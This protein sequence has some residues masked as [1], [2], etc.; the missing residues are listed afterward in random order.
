ML[1]LT[2]IPTLGLL[3]LQN[4][5]VQTTVSEYITKNLSGQLGVDI[6]VSSVHYSFFK[7]LQLNNVYIADRSGDTLMYAE[8]C[9][10]QVKHFR[11]DKKLIRIRKLSFENALL[12]INMDESN[13]S[14]LQFFVD[15][16]RRDLPPEEKNVLEINRME[17][18]DSRYRRVDPHAQTPPSGVDLKN[19]EIRDLDIDIRDFRFEA[20]TTSMRIAAA[21]GREPRGFIMQ[22]VAFDLEFSKKYMS[23]TRGTIV[24]PHSTA[25]IA[26][27]AFSY[28]NPRNFK[29]A[30]D[31]VYMNLDTRGSE[32]D[33]KDIVL[34]F[35]QVDRLSGKILLDGKLTGLLGDLK[36]SDIYL[37]YLDQTQLEFDMALAGLP[38]T[39]SLFMD[40]NFREFRTVPNE[41]MEL[42]KHY[43]L[44]FLKG[45][46]PY[47]G[48]EFVAYQGSFRGYKTDFETAGS[49]FSNLGKVH[50]D[51]NMRP[52]TARMLTV[53]GRLSSDGFDL[54]NLVGNSENLG[55]VEFN[56]ELDGVKDGD[57]LMALVSGT[58][59]TLGIYGY[60][61]SNIRL[62]G[63]F[64][65]KKFDGSVVIR[66]PHI[67]VVFSG[68]VDFENKIPAFD[69]TMDVARLRPY[70]LNLRD[71][72]PA[73]FTSFL[74]ETDMTGS[75]LNNLNGTIELV[76]S[77]FRRTGKE[78]RLRDM[79]LT[80]R[81][82]PDTSW[83]RLRS[84]PLDAEIS[85]N[86]SMA[87]L[88]ELFTSLV[89]EHFNI[90]RNHPPKADRT[91]SFS[92][93][94]HFK[95]TEQWLDFFFPRF[96]AVPGII[97]EG[98]L[99]QLEKD[100]QFNLRGRLPEV[101]FR[102]VTAR[103]LQFSIH[104]D[105]A[106][107]SLD[108]MSDQ[109]LSSSNLEIENTV[110]SM[111]FANDS[112][113]FSFQ[114][115]NDSLPLYAGNI[116]STGI[117]EQTPGGDLV[118]T[119]KINPSE[120]HYDN[121]AFNIPGS[122]LKIGTNGMVMDSIYVIGTDQYL[123][124]HGNYTGIPGDS[125]TISMQNLNLQMINHIIENMP[126]D[127]E[128]FLSGQTTLKTEANS[129]VVTSNLTASELM[130]NNHHLGRVRILADWIRES[131]ELQLGI[132]SVAPAFSNIIDIS[133]TYQPAGNVID[134][135]TKLSAVK[136]SM[137]DQYFEN[138]LE[139]LEGEADIDLVLTGTLTDPEIN[140]SI[141]FDH[142]SL[143]LK[144]TKARYSIS[145]QI[146][147]NSNDIYFDNF[148]IKDEF[149][150]TVIANG[151][152][153][154]GNFSELRIDLDL[155]ADNFN[156]LQTTRFDNEQFYGDIFASGLIN[157]EGPADQ[158][159]VKATANTER[160]TNLKLPLYN[161]SEIQTTDFI[162]FIGTDHTDETP[163]PPLKTTG[164][165]NFTLDMELDVSSNTTVQLI[166]D[167]KVGD[168]IEA[169]GE[170]T[171]KFEIDE[172]GEFS[173]FGNVLIQ[174][175]EYLFT[176]QNVINKRFRVKPGGSISWNGPPRSAILD[177]D[178]IYET[179]ASTFNLSPEPSE[180]M[181]KRIPVHCLL[182]LEG[183]LTNPTIKPSI[184]LPTA[185]PE[186]RSL[187]QTSIGTDE[188][189]MRQFISLLV[190]NNFISSSEFGVS[191][192]AGT[193]TGVAGVTA[194]ELL[195]NQLSNWLSQISNDFDIGVNYR[196]GDAISS[197][198]VEVALSTQL[199]NDRIV[200]SGNLDVLADEVTTPGGEASNIVGDFDLEFRVSDKISLK[201][202]NRVNDDRSFRPSLYTQ[203]VGV[204][205]RSEFNSLSDFFGKNEEEKDDKDNQTDDQAIREEENPEETRMEK[206]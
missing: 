180:E 172:S 93:K 79:L 132:A 2:S 71:D 23:F 155:T 38:S 188:E 167:P 199:L 78:A 146:A 83:V 106:E 90:F 144:K 147:L 53:E 17:F 22:E 26:G 187:L 105:T 135:K 19:M 69:F 159:R 55:Q 45:S 107:L 58:I 110:F 141:M 96:S 165:N 67:D 150:S 57:D 48:L 72:D 178:A 47:P 186:T 3:F 7:R 4:K 28:N 64:T 143:M 60:D 35:P 73:Y 122:A 87:A 112:N 13:N 193:S 151:T 191:P 109:L 127:L 129:P 181:K 157:L 84:D 156:F 185:E 153:F 39:D 56:M 168:I 20:D 177:L 102:Q 163:V 50:I 152:V 123:L 173:M 119:M 76:N 154:T 32:L 121:R 9:N 166:F 100:Y 115:D 140:G 171:L 80:A 139:D 196:P 81:N 117:L 68:R 130:V 134:L 34:F 160:R 27:L 89:N 137:A 74:L 92:I 24:T 86:Y 94:A 51:L 99:E 192:I 40:F 42:T 54:G 158:L 16:L 175:G 98:S 142:S 125:V 114:W 41:F 18:I 148:V 62:E 200:F 124:A 131:R 184:E 44:A 162:S 95:D 77:E 179:K 190:I 49:I 70:Y 113:T 149:G 176:L 183:E 201:A 206:K 194:S 169:S 10:L 161:A 164:Q 198:E 36:G 52:D 111:D 1:V 65:N 8:L 104:S 46:E 33:F 25:R 30:F 108:L 202:F 136:L 61:Y 15:S 11:P 145:D 85:G 118:Y 203:G 75:N 103:N 204:I 29:H 126:A 97:L 43:D 14:S 133:G 88:P 5:Q 174:D 6:S 63:L 31:S 182:S 21:S 101:G 205:Y 120:M 170:G 197:D 59:D 82:T 195:S 12:Q 37:S 189:L 116:T 128:G 138:L 91:A 66:D